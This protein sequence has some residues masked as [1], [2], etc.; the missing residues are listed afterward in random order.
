MGY[1]KAGMLKYLKEHISS[2]NILPILVIRSEGY[3]N[4]EPEIIRKVME[5]AQ[6]NPLIIRSS[7]VMEDMADSSNA[8]RFESVLNVMPQYDVVRSAIE[9]VHESYGTDLDEEMLIQPRLQNIKKSGVVFTADIDTLAD[10]YVV[11]YSED[12]DSAAVTSGNTNALRTYVQYKFSKLPAKDI[13]MESLLAVC[14]QIECLL[15][16]SALDIEFAMDISGKIYIFQV[17]PIAKGEKQFCKPI[18][19]A[20]TLN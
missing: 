5:F 6:N 10:Y 9:K 19:L 11:N 15:G 2:I 1:T 17:R 16:N 20:P 18:D 12:D 3:R 7:S 8:G 14:R 4:N 13:E